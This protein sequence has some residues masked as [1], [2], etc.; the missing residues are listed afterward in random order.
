MK[1][2]PLF[3]QKRLLHLRNFIKNT[4]FL[5]LSRSPILPGWLLE[6]PGKFNEISWKSQKS[7]KGKFMCFPFPDFF[8][9]QDLF[10]LIKEE[11]SRFSFVFLRRPYRSITLIDSM[12]TLPPRTTS[13]FP[14]SS[15]ISF[16]T[17]SFLVAV[18]TN[19]SSRLSFP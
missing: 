19:S 3:R 16:T 15:F 1:K 8:F 18:C 9:S 2:F 6:F 12:P 4:L 14:N 17:A 11:L 13:I 10:P 5:S 7:G